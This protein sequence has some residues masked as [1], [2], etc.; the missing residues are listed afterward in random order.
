[1]EDQQFE[2]KQPIVAPVL[3]PTPPKKSII[4]P[5]IVTIIIALFVGGAAYGVYYYVSNKKDA[6]QTA[7][8]SGSTTSSTTSV[9]PTTE[10]VSVDF[11]L[12]HTNT[13]DRSYQS[14]PA[15]IKFSP[16]L[17][18][19]TQIDNNYIYSCLREDQVSTCMDFNYANALGSPTSLANLNDT[20]IY[21]LTNWIA[22]STT[23]NPNQLGGFWNST[24]TAAE[25]LAE[26]N[27]VM[28]LKTDTKLTKDMI[29]KKLINPFLT[30]ASFFGISN[31][32][33]IQ[34]ADGTLKGYSFIATQ[35]Q[36]L[37]YHP[38]L[39]VVMVGDV[40]GSNVV[41]THEFYLNDK[42][43]IEV[44]KSYTDDAPNYTNA[45]AALTKTYADANFAYGTDTITIAN[46]ALTV[47]KTLTITAKQ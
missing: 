30:N 27:A 10:D 21:D 11:K 46:Q 32:N 38:R 45:E 1:M 35:G 36:Q 25:K 19:R 47:V 17:S 9:T 28:A 39:F 41:V 29:T 34:N 23:Q 40:K 15:T 43:T 12:E 6:K 20:K 26:Y 31:M 44:Q 18:W 4:R 33:Y 14:I 2:T 8:V 13:Q 42:K 16:Y 3:T 22:V 24:K 7:S 5:I 37:G